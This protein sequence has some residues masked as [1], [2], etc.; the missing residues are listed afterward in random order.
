MYQRFATV[1]DS[2]MAGLDYPAWANYYLNLIKSAGPAPAS[3]LECA[4]GTGL[5]TVELAKL[6]PRIISSD[7]SPDMLQLAAARTRSAGLILPLINQDMRQLT[8]HKPVDAVI[9]A[10]DGVNYLETNA[11]LSAFFASAN[12][13]LRPGGTLAFD[14]SSAHKL[15]TMCDQ[16][17]YFED[18]DE[19]TYLWTNTWRDGAVDMDLSFFVKTASGLYERFDEHQR[20]TAHSVATLEQALTS[21]GFDQIKIYGDRTFSPPEPDSARIHI[22]AVKQCTKE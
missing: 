12:R 9:A 11:D 13:C 20:Q 1:Y 14:V 6:C 21:S 15:K 5:M 8:V 22:T 17:Q 18:L 19:L 2:L 3:I 4:C 10:C 16:R 7:L